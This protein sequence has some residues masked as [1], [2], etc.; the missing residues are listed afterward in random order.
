[1]TRNLNNF[2]RGAMCTLVLSAAMAAEARVVLRLGTVA[3]KGSSWE[4]LMRR[5]GAEWGKESD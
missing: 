3:P 5:M 2:F 4:L 1:M